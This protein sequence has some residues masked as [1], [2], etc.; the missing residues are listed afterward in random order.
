MKKNR[1][2]KRRCQ[3]VGKAKKKKY[4]RTKKFFRYR[5]GKFLFSVTKYLL[6]AIFMVKGSTAYPPKKFGICR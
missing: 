3:C 6:R 1:G 5:D 2:K 4:F